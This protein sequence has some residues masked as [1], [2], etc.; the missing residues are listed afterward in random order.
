MPGREERMS[1]EDNKA[2]VRQFTQALDSNDLSILPEICT[3][4]CADMWSQGINSDPWS[5]H[6][7]DLKQLVA[8]GDHVVAIVE[9]RGRIVGT[10][11]GVPGRG[12][13]FTNRGAVVYR[14]ENQKIASVDIYFDDLRIVTEHLG[15]RLVPPAS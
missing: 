9:T 5:D 1:V 11:Y 12:K 13:S 15:A 14:F 8:E 7:V 6:H 3:P 4:A 2:A 10:Y